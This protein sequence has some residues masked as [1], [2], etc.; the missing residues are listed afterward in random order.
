MPSLLSES[1]LTKP[2]W[3]GSLFSFRE[4]RSRGLGTVEEVN[5]CIPGTLLPLASEITIMARQSGFINPY[6][7]LPSIGTGDLASLLTCGDR[8]GLWDQRPG[9]LG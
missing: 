3:T 1:S 8:I 2:G 7:Q 4:T 5:A 6:C 9:V